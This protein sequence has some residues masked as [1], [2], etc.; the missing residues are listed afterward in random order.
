MCDIYVLDNL[1]IDLRSVYVVELE[2]TSPG[3]YFR[4]AFT[5]KNR[6]HRVIVSLGRDKRAADDEFARIIAALKRSR[7]TQ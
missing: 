7:T 5:L 2:Q 4:A 1:A 6:E 3:C